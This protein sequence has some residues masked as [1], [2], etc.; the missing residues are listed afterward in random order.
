MTSIPKSWYFRRL[1]WAKWEAFRF[2]VSKPKHI[3]QPGDN[4]EIIG[5]KPFPEVYPE[6]NLPNI[7]VFDR[8][9]GKERSLSMR[10]VVGL[11]LALNKRYPQMQPDLPQISADIDTAL[12]E[13]LLPL[14]RA[15]YRFPNKPE[16]FEKEGAPDLGALAVKGPYALLLE[17][18]SVN[19][20]KWDFEDLG[21]YEHQE[22]LASLGIKVVF[23][24]PSTDEEHPRPLH[25]LSEE[26]GEVFPSDKYWD[27]AVLLAMCAATTH[28]SLIR[29][30]NYVHLITANHW[31]CIARNLLPIDHP[32][33]LLLWPHIFDSCYSNYAVIEVQMDP[34][35]DFVNMF[36]FTHRGL[37]DCLS[38]QYDKYDYRLML[39]KEDWKRRG[40]GSCVFDSP[41]QDNLVDLFTVMHEHASRYIHHYYPTDEALAT[42]STIVSWLN[43]L[44]KY[45]PNGIDPSLLEK[46][47]RKALAQLIGG[48]IYEGNSIHELVGSNL[49]DYQL[50]VDKNPV[51]VYQS[52]QRLPL[53]V[54]QRVINNNF[55]LQVERAPLCDD[56][57]EIGLDQ[58][59]HRLFARF[60]IE[61]RELQMRYSLE[62]W[63]ST[64]NFMWRM[65]PR[66]LKVSMNG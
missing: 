52:G 4:Q 2:D 35:G 61:I 57:Q 53:D 7:R 3:R 62:R 8:L 38:D 48:Y 20:L 24:D 55:A 54:Y 9:P 47:T 65:E 16:A 5:L 59:G 19:T 60:A 23:S 44:H 37:M 40:L 39:P 58:A 32:I 64:S 42:D 10:A 11:G 41:G 21:K 33:Y 63:S 17:R 1:F 26:Y 18:D 29:H 51:R 34:D 31:D 6:L 36:S 43:E 50:W 27:D 25:I 49:W 22:G 12:D 66:N 14:Y 15:T 13:A 56:Y 46:P 45:I 30:F 28:L